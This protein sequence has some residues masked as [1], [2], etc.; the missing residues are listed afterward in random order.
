MGLSADEE[1]VRT[2]NQRFY[3]AFESLELSRMEE[4][5]WHEGLVTCI[6]PGWP[7]AAGWGEVRD[8]YRTIF[9]N[10]EHIRFDVSDERIDVRG[11][12]AWVTCVE[13]LMSRSVVGE[14]RGAVV[15]TNVFRRERDAWRMVH[16]HASP[17]LPRTGGAD[18][19]DDDDEDTVPSAG[20]KGEL[21]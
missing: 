11:E 3:R 14:S 1:L 17:F 10:T 4:A 9:A 20:K 8:S 21:N 12:L 19:P 5:W 15:A 7:L 2:A 6:H 18:E 16:H 13:R